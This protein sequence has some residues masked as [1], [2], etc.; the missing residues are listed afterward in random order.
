VSR[1]LNRCFPRKRR[2]RGGKG[3]LTGDDNPSKNCDI[4]LL[5]YFLKIF[6]SA[7]FQKTDFLLVLLKCF[8]KILFRL[9]CLDLTYLKKY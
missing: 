7:F 3:T 2:R 6:K 9:L 4:K 5:L 1:D 8:M